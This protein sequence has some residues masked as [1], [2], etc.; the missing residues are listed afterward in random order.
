MQPLSVF[1][2]YTFSSLW[3]RSFHRRSSGQGHK[4]L[5]L[6][7]WQRGHAQTET[8]RVQTHKTRFRFSRCRTVAAWL[9]SLCWG[10]SFLWS[11]ADGTSFLEE[12][13]KVVRNKGLQSIEHEKLN[14][15]LHL[16]D[17]DF[18]NN[19]SQKQKLTV[20]RCVLC[21]GTGSVK[22]CGSLEEVWQCC[23]QDHDE[24]L[25]LLSHSN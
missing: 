21:V 22:L 9:L 10:P 13:K 11:S 3:G 6:S 4:V 12:H 19:R 17:S 15:M 23:F 8:V 25:Q 7:P 18:T 20:R 16:I 1:F 2:D 5:H 14:R 24:V